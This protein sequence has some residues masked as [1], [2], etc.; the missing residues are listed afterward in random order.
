MCIF[1]KYRCGLKHSDQVPPV[2][3]A[4]LAKMDMILETE[5]SVL[6]KSIARKIVYGRR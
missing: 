6:S 5:E 4:K 1:R 2:T 3:I